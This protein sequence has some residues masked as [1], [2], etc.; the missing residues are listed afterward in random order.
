MPTRSHAPNSSDVTLIANA[1]MYSVAPGAGDAW[2]RLFGHVAT[3]SGIPLTIIDHAF[4]APLSDLWTRDDLACTFLCGWPWLRLGLGHQI[5]AAPV[6]AA[7]YAEDRPVYRT[8]FVVAADSPFAR[9]EDTFGRR[10]AYTIDDSHS[11]YNAPR[12]HLIRHR[13]GT[14]PLFAEIIGPLTTPRRMLEAI[15]D[16]RTDVGPLDSFAY[17]LLRR[18]EP[19]LAAR[20]RTIAATALVP[21]PALMASARMA[22]A[23][24]ER[25]RDVLFQLHET[26]LGRALLA[27]VTAARFAALDPAAYAIAETWAR[28]AEAAGFAR[29][30]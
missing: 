29:I 30:A 14:N 13:V 8:E 3:V 20:T 12:H 17:G 1:R 25:L 24:V 16:G 9:L 28:D 4:P 15:A 10:F 5:V 18:H 7:A 26:T 21:V 22:P 19:A 2:K 11:G 6:P 23:I 27:D